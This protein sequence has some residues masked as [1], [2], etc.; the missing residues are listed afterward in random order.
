MTKI[1]NFYASWTIFSLSDQKDKW[2]FDNIWYFNLSRE[3]CKANMIVKFEKFSIID[4]TSI[5]PNHSI[6]DYL[7]MVLIKWMVFALAMNLMFDKFMLVWLHGNFQELA[8]NIF[9]PKYFSFSIFTIHA[10]TFICGYWPA[11]AQ[12]SDLFKP[13]LFIAFLYHTH[14]HFHNLLPFAFFFRCGIF[15]WCN[16]FS[17]TNEMEVSNGFTSKLFAIVFRTLSKFPPL[18]HWTQPRMRARIISRIFLLFG[19]R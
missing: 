14:R 18:V 9:H 6:K 12:Y 8:L 17:A 15:S 10:P 7:V 11:K 19:L 13:L 3:Y 2:D 16:N 4:N 1:W 5:F